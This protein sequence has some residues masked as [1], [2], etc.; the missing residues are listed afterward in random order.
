[1][2]CQCYCGEGETCC[3]GDLNCC[4]TI[5]PISGGVCYYCPTSNCNDCYIYNDCG[6]TAINFVVANIKRLLFIG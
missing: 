5:T 3:D 4:N 2:S 1:M 6:K